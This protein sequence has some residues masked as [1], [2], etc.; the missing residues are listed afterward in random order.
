MAI[1]EQ[2]LQEKSEFFSA[3]MD[4]IV[5]VGYP[6]PGYYVDEYC[7]DPCIYGPDNQPRRSIACDSPIGIL[8]DFVKV[9]DDDNY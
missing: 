2:D 3:V 1:D 9:L 7:G 8:R 4:A 5:E 6:D